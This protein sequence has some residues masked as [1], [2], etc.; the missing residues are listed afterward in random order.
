MKGRKGKRWGEI[1]GWEEK[2]DGIGQKPRV[3]TGCLMLES[4]HPRPSK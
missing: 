2:E 4:N 3:S 1:L